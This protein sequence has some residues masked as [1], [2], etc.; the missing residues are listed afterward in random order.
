MP[1][2]LLVED[3]PPIQDVIIRILTRAGYEV[4]T[5]SNGITALEVLEHQTPDLII[6]DI[7]MPILDG[8]QFI[9]EDCLRPGPLPPILVITAAVYAPQPSAALGA[10]GYLYKPFALKEL[11]SK[12]EE[13][14]GPPTPGQQT[15]RPRG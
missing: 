12:V 4:I 8:R 11:L 7:Y 14:L 13:L 9:Q 1:L 10:A 5:A 6:L 2:I 15:G 3:D